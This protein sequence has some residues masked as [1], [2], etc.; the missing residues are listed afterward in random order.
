MAGLIAVLL[1]VA[2]L[3][4][5]CFWDWLRKVSGGYESGTATVRNL[6]L[7]VTAIIALPLAIWRSIVADRQGETAWRQSE[8]AAHGLLNERYQ[9]GRGHVG[10]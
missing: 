6:G 2:G 1:V 4:V 7:L 8:T 9:K 5:W 10:K 3:F